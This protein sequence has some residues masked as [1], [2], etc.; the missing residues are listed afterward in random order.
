MSLIGSVF[1]LEDFAYPI[2]HF[3]FPEKQTEG[4]NNVVTSWQKTALRDQ[5]LKFDGQPL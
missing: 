5:W 2:D 3:L 4:K 1:F